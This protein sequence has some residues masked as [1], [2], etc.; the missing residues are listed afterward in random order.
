[1]IMITSSERLCARFWRDIVQRAVITSPKWPTSPAQRAQLFVVR[2][3]VALEL[4]V[5]LLRIQG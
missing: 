4:Q 5:H 3:S 1:M 2:L